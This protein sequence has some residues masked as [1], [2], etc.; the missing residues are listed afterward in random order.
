MGMRMLY[1]CLSCTDEVCAHTKVFCTYNNNLER[2]LKP[3][4]LHVLLGVERVEPAH[5]PNH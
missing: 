3:V 2:V 1:I 5:N 4:D